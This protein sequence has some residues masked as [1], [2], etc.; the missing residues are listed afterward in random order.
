MLCC[1]V[2]QVTMFVG[3]MVVTE[4]RIQARRLDWFCC[5]VRPAPA[6]PA[7]GVVQAISLTPT[8]HSNVTPAEPFKRAS[9]SSDG[10]PVADS[11]GSSQRTVIQD[12]H[13]AD[14]NMV[15]RVFRKHCE[16]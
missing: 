1:A 2:L 3:F 8:T 4:R 5:V 9:G 11:M 7:S 6:A 10:S 12:D 14:E 13:I 15:K 16:S